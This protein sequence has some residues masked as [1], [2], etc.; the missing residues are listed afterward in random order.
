MLNSPHIDYIP[1]SVPPGEKH[2]RTWQ[3]TPVAAISRF[4]SN[5]QYAFQKVSEI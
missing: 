2:F 4:W 1:P 3:L 5:I